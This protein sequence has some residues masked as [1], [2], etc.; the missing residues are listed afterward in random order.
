MRK[1]RGWLLRCVFFPLSFGFTKEGKHVERDS[2]PPPPPPPPPRVD[3]ALKEQSKQTV[4]WLPS[5][6][7]AVNHALWVWTTIGVYVEQRLI[8]QQTNKWMSHSLQMYLSS[9]THTRT[10]T[11]VVWGDKCPPAGDD[12][13]GPTMINA[14]CSLSL[15]CDL[16][17]K[18]P[19]WAAS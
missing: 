3:L 7:C 5:Q 16:C 14:E 18:T 10:L 11:R 13:A 15:S 4:T 8:R 17:A 6:P 1:K 19:N 2:L 12:G 9:G